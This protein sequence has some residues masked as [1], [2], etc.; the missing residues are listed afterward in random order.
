MFFHS[1]VGLSVDCPFLVSED[2]LT[3]HARQSRNFLNFCSSEKFLFL[4]Y[5]FLR[6][7]I[8]NVAQDDLI[9]LDSSY[10]SSAFTFCCWV[11]RNMPVV[12]TFFILEGPFPR[13]LDYIF[14]PFQHIKY[15]TLLSSHLR[16]FRNIQY[17]N[18]CL[19]S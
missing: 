11:S 18:S 1:L 2:L 14:S 10:H 19:C 6:N 4:L 13:I 17:N 7:G 3:I 12:P 8:L 9:L 15:F 16:G 5:P